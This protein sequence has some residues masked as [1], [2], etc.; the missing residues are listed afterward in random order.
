M[1]V[2]AHIYEELANICTNR[3]LFP[4]DTISHA[5]ANEC[6]KRGWAKRDFDGHYVPTG[7]G[8]AAL[9]AWATDPPEEE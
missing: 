5:T 7:E 9:Q 8:V 4:G 6:V 3:P 1:I 2:E